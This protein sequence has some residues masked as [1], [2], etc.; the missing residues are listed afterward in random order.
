MTSQPPPDCIILSEVLRM[1]VSAIGADLYIT[2][3]GSSLFTGQS[4]LTKA[5][6]VAQ[7]VEAI[8]GEGIAPDQIQVHNISINNES[9]ALTKSS[10]AQYTLKIRTKL[11]QLPDLLS[12]AATAKNASLQS[13]NW[14]YDED[15]ERE[16]QWLEAGLA[17]AKLRAERIARGLG[18]KIIGIKECRLTKSPIPDLAPPG[19]APM[20]MGARRRVQDN[21][22][23]G[24]PIAQTTEKFVHIDLQFRIETARNAD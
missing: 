1:E 23:L 21:V 18:V 6:E 11:E 13:I 17:Q 9:G 24:M 16:L 12:I 20:M 10:S 15:E 5:K 2:V 14:R 3:R 7:L 22:D 8:V 19:M 4:A